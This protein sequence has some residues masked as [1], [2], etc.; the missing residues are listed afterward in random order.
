MWVY[1]YCWMFSCSKTGKEDCAGYG[2]S[3]DTA[4]VEA[5]DSGWYDTSQPEQEELSEPSMDSEDTSTNEN[6]EEEL[7]LE[8]C[9]GIEICD[10][11]ED[12]TL[13]E[14]PPSSRWTIETPNCSGNGEV[15]IANDVTHSGTQSVKVM[16]VGGYCDHIFI[17]PTEDVSSIGPS[18]YGRFWMRIDSAF[19]WE[20][21]TFLAMKDE[22]EG[23]DLRMGGQ[24]QV[25][26]WNRESDDA[27]LPEL[28]PTGISLS[29]APVPQTWMCVL[30]M[31]D[32]LSG[33]I[34]TWIDGEFIEGLTQDNEATPDVD[35]QWVQQKPGWTPSLIDIKLGWESYGGGSNVVWYDDVAFSSSPLSCD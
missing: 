20:H 13:N 8:P 24:S 2:C 19:G 7:P 6:T 29:H 15:M 34:N 1:F 18:F 26:M 28:S 25:M 31:V 22:I 30:F 17:A 14:V 4:K 35:R 33:T 23:K 5:E 21:I 12:Y 11:F 9:D 27:T 3:E 10:D 32:E 16:G